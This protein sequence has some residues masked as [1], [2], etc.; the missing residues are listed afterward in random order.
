MPG[1][2]VSAGL[3]NGQ[4]WVRQGRDLRV[5]DISDL[6][7]SEADGSTE[8]SDQ[9]GLPESLE[10]PDIDVGFGEDPGCDLIELSITDT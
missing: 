4:T 6:G 10:I 8:G 7:S 5:V 1:E 2:E 9:E 3:S